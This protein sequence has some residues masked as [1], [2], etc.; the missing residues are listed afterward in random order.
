MRT[1]VELTRSQKEKE[2]REES[3]GVESPPP[4]APKAPA[5]N[6]LKTEDRG[7]GWMALIALSAPHEVT[8]WPVL[9]AAPIA[10]NDFMSL[11]WYMR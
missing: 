5:I 9:S 10:M 11:C 4:D 1:G 3:K 6:V 8:A 7:F 2:Q